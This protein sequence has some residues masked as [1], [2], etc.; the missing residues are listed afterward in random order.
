MDTYYITK[1]V[2]R[3]EHYII[4]ATSKEI[5]MKQC[6]Y[7]D[8]EGGVKEISSAIIDVRAESE[9][10]LTERVGK[11]M[12]IKTESIDDIMKRFGP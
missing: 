10:D 5:A 4:Q 9:E 2:I 12:K 8:P 7:Q 3:E 6:E 1:R 11:G